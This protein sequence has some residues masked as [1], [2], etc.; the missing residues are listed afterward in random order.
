VIVVSNRSTV[1][2]A[3]PDTAGLA[4]TERV[5]RATL[6]AAIVLAALS[7][8]PLVTFGSTFILTAIL[9]IIYASVAGAIVKAQPAASAARIATVF[10]WI[11]IGIVAIELVTPVGRLVALVMGR[12]MPLHLLSMLL[13][14]AVLIAGGRA[15]RGSGL[16]GY[17]WIVLAVT[18]AGMVPDG[19]MIVRLMEWSERV[20]AARGF[21]AREVE[22]RKVFQVQFDS[23]RAAVYELG[24][25]LRE[26]AARNGGHYPQALRAIA[27]VSPACANTVATYATI[28]RSTMTYTVRDATADGPSGFEL[29]VAPVSHPALR[30]ASTIH[31]DETSIVWSQ[32]NGQRR[33]INYPRQPIGTI[34]RCLREFRKSNPADAYPATL[35]ELLTRHTPCSRYQKELVERLSQDAILHGYRYTY[36]PRPADAPGP[37][38]GYRIDARPVRFGHGFIR[39]YMCDTDGRLRFTDDDRAAEHT[40]GN[41]ELN[42]VLAEE[43][44]ADCVGARAAGTAKTSASEDEV[45]QRRQTDD[46]T[47][48]RMEAPA[49]PPIWLLETF[50]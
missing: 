49:S 28:K 30:Y 11:G 14:H 43:Q 25:C 23:S 6:V 18:I 26:H 13:G 42:L 35:G 41:A 20:K 9:W 7:F 3:A 5:W 27:S 50:R 45:R 47:R 1:T 46:L 21:A 17:P 2:D 8:I 36:T 33:A 44:P 16:R 31:T 15:L 12:A 19:I 29:I 22:E 24:R 37:I 32:G 38:R 34:D 48:A 39:S 4:H 40:D 10:G